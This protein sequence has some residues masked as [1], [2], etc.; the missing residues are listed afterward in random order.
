MINWSLGCQTLFCTTLQPFCPVAIENIEELKHKG[1]SSDDEFFK[2]LSEKLSGAYWYL[3]DWL[4]DSGRQMII[5]SEK[6]EIVFAQLT[7]RWVSG[8]YSADFKSFKDRDQNLS[9]SRI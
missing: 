2:A 1:L 5:E 8:E 9:L 3:F 6:F 4:V 7:H